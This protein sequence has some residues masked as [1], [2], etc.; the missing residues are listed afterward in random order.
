MHF[1]RLALA[2]LFAHSLS[3]GLA[4]GE[5]SPEVP[6]RGNATDTAAPDRRGALHAPSNSATKEVIRVNPTRTNLLLFPTGEEVFYEALSPLNADVFAAGSAGTVLSI[7]NHRPVLHT[8]HLFLNSGK[9]VLTI[10]TRLANIRLNPDTTVVL[11][12]HPHK[13]LHIEVL[14]G[15]TP[16]HVKLR[17]HRTPVVLKAG[18]ELFVSDSTLPLD[19]CQANDPIP[20][21]DIG[22][23]SAS[24]GME[25]VRRTFDAKKLLAWQVNEIVSKE[26]VGGNEKAFLD[27]LSPSPN[28]AGVIDRQANDP[29]HI[30]AAGGSEFKLLP[31]NSGI[32][33]LR[34]GELFI[35][36][37]D[38]AI[39]ET[40]LGEVHGNKGA[41]FAVDT[42]EG[43]LRARALTGPGDVTV[44]VGKHKLP[45][46]PGEE[47]M[48]SDHVPTKDD[49]APK[50]GVARRKP[51][52]KPLEDKMHVTVSDFNI[53]SL[54]VSA[55]YLKPIKKPFWSQEKS[56]LE[57]LIQT[58]AAIETITQSKGGYTG[59]PRATTPKQRVNPGQAI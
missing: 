15:T 1:S 23:E 5:P 8:G 37:T 39:V 28:S 57:K 44:I 30:L 58:A 56:A 21:E 18:E 7:D 35:F 46:P 42:Y 55:D 41:I 38:Y 20:R 31:S 26:K 29:W 13:P 51:V 54:L 32:I 22:K 50:D 24:K 47:V 25:F 48:V 40:P 3:F 16:A 34:L 4:F 33:Q 12:I 9:H 6:R 49:M 10:G 17:E 59:S 53:L 14:S 19:Q 52:A 43:T 36:T 27:K 45:V 11:D 2:L